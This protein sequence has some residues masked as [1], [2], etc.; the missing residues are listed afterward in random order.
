MGG[1]GAP[2]DVDHG[3]DVDPVGHHCRYEGVIEQS[4]HGGDGYRPDPV[5]D[6]ALLVLDVTAHQGGVIDQGHHRGRRAHPPG[7]PR[8]TSRPDRP[9]PR[10]PVSGGAGAGAGGVGGLGG[11]GQ[12]GVG[13]VAFWFLAP[14]GLAGGVE[15]LGLEG[16]QAGLEAGQP[17][18]GEP[19]VEPAGAVP[20][21]PGAQVTAPM[22]RGPPGRVIGRGP[23]GRDHL[24]ARV[25]QPG[26]AL[27]S[28]R[29]DQT[30]GAARVHRRRRRDLAG[31]GRRQPAGLTGPSQLR[32]GVHL[33]GH[34][35][36][37]PGR[38]G[39]AARHLGQPPL[40]VTVTSGGPLAG[41]AGPPGGHGLGRGT[42][43]FPPGEQ[44]G[45]LGRVAPRQPG[46]I[47]APHQAGQRLDHLPRP[48]RH[49]RHRAIHQS[50][51]AG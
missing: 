22:Q 4:P 3:P 50:L 15:L 14:T 43:P 46:H 39:A 24:T 37:G 31:L 16:A 11:E 12:E 51:R 33:L 45:Q 29:V 5:D 40:R 35:Q 26:Q 38:P 2:A 1:G 18:G 7:R 10:S 48:H 49:H 44:P 23:P 17:V 21:G 41:L 8:R 32:S 13:G 42:Q 36:A 34:G 30:R 27:P 19:G 9:V 6:A 20:V 47:Q 25:A 28:R